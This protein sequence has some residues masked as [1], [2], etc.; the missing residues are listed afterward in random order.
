MKTTI[1]AL[2]IVL[3]TSAAHAM[4]GYEFYQQCD[5]QR[6]SPYYFQDLAFCTGFVSGVYMAGSGYC[7]PN[8]VQVGM[9]RMVVLNYMRTH[10]QDLA[11]EAATVVQRAYANPWPCQNIR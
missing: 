4:T 2:V 9:E 7:P 8:T 1:T 3:V 5:A 10:P 11:M 6:S